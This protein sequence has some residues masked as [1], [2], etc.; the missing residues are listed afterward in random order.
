MT[1]KKRGFTLIELLVV[2][3]IIAVLISLL[4]PAVQQ[5]REAARRTQCKNNIKQLG[6]ALHNY[7]DTFNMFPPGSVV[8]DT[9]TPKNRD[10]SAAGL[11]AN[12]NAEA[13]SMHGDATNDAGAPWPVLVLPYIEQ[14]NLYDTFDLSG[15][16]YSRYDLRGGWAQPPNF[17]AQDGSSP[18][19]MRCPSN[20]NVTKDPYILSYYGCSGGGLTSSLRKYHDNHGVV[21]NKTGPCWTPISGGSARVFWD[22][23]M[24]YTNSNVNISEVRDGATNTI[25]VGEQ[26]YVGLDRVYNNNNGGAYHWTWA[27][28]SRTHNG[29]SPNHSSLT[30]TYDGINNPTFSFTHQAAVEV[31]GAAKAHT[32]MMM[33]YSSWHTG[34]AHM[35]FGDGSVTFLSEN[36]DLATYRVLGPKA[37][38]SIVAG[39][40]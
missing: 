30:N 22:S 6:L 38:G 40:F 14:T 5:A 36:M 35:C 18:V 11:A 21:Y 32:Q 31:T 12:S 34:G 39:A 10:S 8:R 29:N 2:I 27:A 4:L 25:M 19:S 1:L 23:G 20:P 16:F 3:A 37:D 26:M 28:G 7:H 13:C 24:L 15:G 33:A 9:Q 17:V